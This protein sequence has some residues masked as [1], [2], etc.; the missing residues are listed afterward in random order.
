MVRRECR[1]IAVVE[2]AELDEQMA[3]ALHN[4]ILAMDFSSEADVRRTVWRTAERIAAS[5]KARAYYDGR[6]E[7]HRCGAPSLLAD[8]PVSD[9][10]ERQECGERTAPR[11]PYFTAYNEAR[12]RFRDAG[13]TTALQ[14]RASSR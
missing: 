8:L 5:S 13:A 1:R 12:T 7:A 9:R 10:G 11:N 4:S 6:I 3:D 14:A 2:P